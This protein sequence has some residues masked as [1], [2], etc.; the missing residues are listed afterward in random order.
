MAEES[1]SVAGGETGWGRQQKPFSGPLQR[2]INE[3]GVQR[4][5]SPGKLTS[6]AAAI[7]PQQPVLD[8]ENVQLLTTIDKR[9]V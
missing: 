9:L 2:I 6:G 4:S 5:K 1:S 8:K 7:S 3:T